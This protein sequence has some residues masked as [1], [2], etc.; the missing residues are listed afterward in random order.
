MKFKLLSKETMGIALFLLFVVLMSQ[1]R[2]FD[3]LLETTLG[4]AL[5]L[6]LLLVISYCYKILGV[7]SI[8][9]VVIL[10]NNRHELYYEGFETSDASGNMM[11]ASGNMSSGPDKKKLIAAKKIR[12]ENQDASGNVA[13]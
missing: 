13:V 2:M 6:I 8:L 1:S 10:F 3:F 11:D 12:S 9:L 5:F 7:V 4:R